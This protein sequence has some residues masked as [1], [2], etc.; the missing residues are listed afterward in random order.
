MARHIY[1]GAETGTTANYTN[2]VLT[3]GEIDIQKMTAS[4]PTSLVMGDTIA[5]APQIRVVQ[6]NGT[7]N[8]TPRGRVSTLP[9]LLYS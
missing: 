4:G 2:G 9:R 3:S 5:N 6:G 7:T 1:V 8:R